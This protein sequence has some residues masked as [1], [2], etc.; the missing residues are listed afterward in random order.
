MSRKRTDGLF[1]RPP[2]SDSFWNK[3]ALS[4]GEEQ[5][6]KDDLQEINVDNK[7]HNPCYVCGHELIWGG[8]HDVEDH[9]EFTI[10]T[11]LSCP[12]CGAY[13]E[14]YWSEKFDKDGMYK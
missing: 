13:M 5:K 2:S 3:N 7:K 8:D 6:M 12:N 11:N 9:E 14:V 1:N 10:I 4:Y